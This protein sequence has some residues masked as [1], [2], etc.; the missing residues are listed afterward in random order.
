MKLAFYNSESKAISDN[1][2][3]FDKVI[4]TFQRLQGC[5]EDSKFVHVE[6]VFNELD[7]M[8]CSTL[9]EE[10]HRKNRLS[11]LN[12]QSDGNPGNPNS[13]LCY[14]SS[15]RDDGVR[16]KWI[17][18]EDGKWEILNLTFLKSE[19]SQKALTF[20]SLHLGMK[21]DWTGILGFALPGEQH[22]NKDRFCSEA[23]VELLNY[24]TNKR[25]LKPWDVSPAELYKIIKSNSY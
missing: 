7:R 18:L 4:K 20:A 23:A 2:T 9:D 25:D 6:F 12:I 24:L 8:L 10:I 3:I 11:G 22:D 13:S 14:S 5:G 1:G 15:S 17:N 21:Y 16:L 19:D